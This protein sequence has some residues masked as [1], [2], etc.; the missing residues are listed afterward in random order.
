MIGFLDP[1]CIDISKIELD[2]AT[3]TQGDMPSDF[4]T[5]PADVAG[6]CKANLQDFKVMK[7]EAKAFQEHVKNIQMC[8]LK[9]LVTLV[10]HH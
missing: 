6:P 9:I 3:I 2:I 10:E 5:N 4:I 7:E 8:S 1:E